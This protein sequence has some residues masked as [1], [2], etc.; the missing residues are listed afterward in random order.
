MAFSFQPKVISDGMILYLDAANTRSYP[1]SGTTWT[2]LRSTGIT[3][4]LTNGPTFSSEKVGGIVFDGTNDYVNMG[5][6]TNLQFTNTQ[7]FTISVW[8]KWTETRTTGSTLFAYSL[9]SGDYRGYYLS[10]D[11]GEYGFGTNICL[12][13]YYDGTTYRG[14][15]S[16]SNSIPKDTWFNLCGT[17]DSSNSVNGMKIYVNGLQVSSSIRS[18]G[19]PSTINFSGLNAQIASREGLN[20]FK[21]NISSISIYNRALSATEVLQNYNALSGRFDKTPSVTD[22]DALNFVN[23]ALISNETQQIAINT[24]TT[25]LKN[26]GLWSKMKAIYPFVGGTAASHKW[27]LKDPRDLDAAFRLSFVGGWTHSST[28]ADPNGTN[29]YAN[30]FLWHAGALQRDSA[31]LSIYIREIS[32]Q[33]SPTR[34]PIGTFGANGGNAFSFIAPAM[35]G[36]STSEGQMNG[37]NYN[38]AVYT[39]TKKRGYYTVSR[40]LST[41]YEIYDTGASR[42]TKLN[43][44]SAYTDNLARSIYIGALNNLD[45]VGGAYYYTDSQISFATI[46]DGLTDTDA[47]NLYTIVQ[48][49]QTTLGRQV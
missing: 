36:G 6:V 38:P 27:N 16:P 21:G 48:K 9:W 19:T 44:S 1:G 42:Q 17:S 23:A 35:S 43:N 5:S 2:D 12:Y 45:G 49:Y 15:I 34:I 30:T 39:D 24:L 13:D 41:E 47:A 33:N 18:A 4:S 26:A 32:T 37:T 10:L 40:T 3:G 29:G 11:P 7:P 31:H 25:D 46:G 8:A 28:G 14:L 22:Y 20:L